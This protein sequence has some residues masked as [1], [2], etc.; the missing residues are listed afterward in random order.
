[1]TP[2]HW[3]H[4]PDDVQFVSTNTDK[5][6][7]LAGWTRHSRDIGQRDLSRKPILTW[8]THIRGVLGQVIGE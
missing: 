3:I 5:N 4:L 2:P 6:G 7:V 8:I 1:M